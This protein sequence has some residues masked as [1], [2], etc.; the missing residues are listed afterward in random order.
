MST[1]ETE[2]DNLDAISQGDFEEDFENDFEDANGV[3]SGADEYSFD[4]EVA[5]NSPDMQDSGLQSEELESS[6]NNT[7]IEEPSVPEDDDEEL[8]KEKSFI[9][10]NLVLIIIGGIVLP[11]LAWFIYSIISPPAKTAAIQNTNTGISVNG[12]QF[13]AAPQQSMPVVAKPVS[14]PSLQVEDDAASST[15]TVIDAISE[16]DVI[17]MVE[18][19]AEQI[20]AVSRS[21][22]DINT[23]LKQQES[24][25]VEAKFGE[26]D[27]NVI[28]EAINAGLDSTEKY[29]LGKLGEL[30]AENQKLAKRIAALEGE[31]KKFESRRP[32]TMVTASEG[33]A[34]MRITGTDTEFSIVDGESIKGYGKVL[35]VG[36]WGCLHLQ[37]GEK[38]QPENASCAE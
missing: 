28:K 38:F 14:K 8:P 6:D 13:N 16:D 21:I 7:V 22:N 1:Q 18:P 23:Y 37:Y 34:I 12:S 3:E 4:E 17:E 11:V 20:A 25:I 10:K 33:K 36:P 26:N 5:H 24:M 30:S 29:L 27:L 2:F 31:R 9:Q 32:L 19:L 35:R 15:T